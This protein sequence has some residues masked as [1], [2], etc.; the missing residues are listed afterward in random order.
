[1]PKQSCCYQYTGMYVGQQRSGQR[2]W[3]I[4][5]YAIVAENYLMHWRIW[6]HLHQ[7]RKKYSSRSE[8]KVCFKHA[9]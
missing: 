2:I 9:G 8:Y 1:M 5:L 3:K 7:Q 4:I 6:K